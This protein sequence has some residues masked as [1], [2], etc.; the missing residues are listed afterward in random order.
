MPR[1]PERKAPL[2][3]G[4]VALANVAEGLYW[5]SQ[6]GLPGSAE[7]ALSCFGRAMQNGGV[8]VVSYIKWSPEPDWIY[9]MNGALYNGVIELMD[10]FGLYFPADSFSNLAQP[11]VVAAGIGANALEYVVKRKQADSKGAAKPR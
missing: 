6:P 9:N 2:L 3:N 11:A 4:V 10:L 7:R 8:C 5:T 1:L